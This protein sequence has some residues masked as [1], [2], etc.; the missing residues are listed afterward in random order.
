LR[1][2][3][4]LLGFRAWKSVGKTIESIRWRVTPVKGAGI[5][6][7]IELPY[8]ANQAHKGPPGHQNS[9]TYSGLMKQLTEGIGRV[10]KTP[11]P[12]H[13]SRT[14]DINEIVVDV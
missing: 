5:R 11:P 10:E 4:L 9:P 12:V 7:L 6:E 8:D 1:L 3:V 13:V 14:K 2:L